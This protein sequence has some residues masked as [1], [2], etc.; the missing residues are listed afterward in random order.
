[1]PILE[2]L[3]IAMETAYEKYLN[4][5]Q[6]HGRAFEIYEK[7]MDAPARDYENARRSL[8][9]AQIAAVGAK[10]RV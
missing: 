9:A 4:L 2:N 3:R 10:E 6:G 1:M 5:L 7:S 8:R